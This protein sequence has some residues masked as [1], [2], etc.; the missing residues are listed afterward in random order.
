MATPGSRTLP[1]RRHIVL[2][3]CLAGLALGV[4]GFTFRY[5]EG[6]SYFS[7]DPKACAN[8]HIMNDQYASWSK[9]PHHAAARCVDCHLPHDLIPKYLA[10]AANGY[11]HSK[12]FTFQDFHEPIRIKPA[13]AAIL[14]QSCLRCH[15]DFV[16]EIL[17]GSKRGDDSVTCVHCHRDAGHGARG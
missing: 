9:G 7:T 4:A 6:L 2:S 1:T 17:E 14:Q 13:N 12:G 8:C 15:G 10:K 16:N 5:G 3:A 11:H